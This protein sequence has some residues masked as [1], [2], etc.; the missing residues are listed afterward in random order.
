MS[1]HSKWA[2]IKHKKAK[3]DAVRGK[4]F[5]KI[6]REIAVAVKEGG[7]DPNSNSRL[8]DAIS[9]AK[10]NNMP[11]DGIS[12]AIKKASGDLSSVNY[13]SITYEGYGPNGTAFIV[14]TLTD[15]KNRTAGDIRHYFD[16]SGGSLGQIGCV[17]YMFD[18]KGVIEI[19]NEK[20]EEDDAFMIAVDA[21]AED[22]ISTEESYLIYTEVSNFSS[23]LANIEK[24]GLEIL[25]SNLEYIPQNVLYIDNESQ[26]KRITKL[27]DTLEEM[28]DVQNLHYNVELVEG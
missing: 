16:K 15:N 22:V 28:D 21:G 9:K 24:A 26:I 2:T 7:S 13:E 5:T 4:I 10:S 14:E 18:R 25:E 11:N 17:S 6:G 27:I 19:S 20:L 1:G 8:R 12:R 23:V 3:D